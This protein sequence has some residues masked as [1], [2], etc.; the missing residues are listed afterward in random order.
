VALVWTA[1][2]QPS[3]VLAWSAPRPEPAAHTTSDANAK[4]D[5]STRWLLFCVRF[6]RD[7][8]YWQTP[9]ALLPHL[10]DLS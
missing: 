4:C 1:P 9:G 2:V 6:V 5:W 8:L 3:L 7:L 10:E